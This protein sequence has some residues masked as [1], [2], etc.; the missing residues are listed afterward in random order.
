MSSPTITTKITAPII[1]QSTGNVP[2]PRRI[3]KRSGRPKCPL[4]QLPISAPI[5]P[6]TIETT[7]PQRLKPAIDWAIDPQMPAMISNR[8]NSRNPNLKRFVQVM[9][10]YSATDRKFEVR[11]IILPPYGAA[12]N[13]FCPT[14]ITGVRSIP[15]QMI[16]I[17][18]RGHSSAALLQRL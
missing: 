14:L 10:E 12:L 9:P 13:P 18:I 1:D 17:R 3:L 6:T 7:Q 4:I 2:P 15:L 8:R 11:G 16:P 5:N